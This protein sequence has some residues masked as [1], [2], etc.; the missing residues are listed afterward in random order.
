[1]SIPFKVVKE[2]L[3]NEPQIPKENQAAPEPE[4]KT[5][6]PR[7]KKKV[8]DY[9]GLANNIA[10]FHEIAAKLFKNDLLQLE[11]NESES[12]A[13][14]IEGVLEHHEITINPLF[15]AYTSLLFVSASIY[16]P[17]I[18]LMK[19]MQAERYR[20]QSLK[21]NVPRE[22]M[23]EVQPSTDSENFEDLQKRGAKTDLD[24]FFAVGSEYDD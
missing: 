16:A 7:T 13:K 14:A 22:T 12:L 10:G 5:R 4:E 20:E 8:S 15:A 3:G 21:R 2:L 11:K 19:Q 1:M 18:Y 6:K 23:A 17:R 9:S 24:N